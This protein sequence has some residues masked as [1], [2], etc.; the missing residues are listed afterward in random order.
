MTPGYK[1]DTTYSRERLLALI[2]V[3]PRLKTYHN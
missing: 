2:A 3:D 1:S